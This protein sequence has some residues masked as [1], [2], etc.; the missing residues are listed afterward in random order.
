MPLLWRSWKSKGNE[1]EE[2]KEG[3]MSLLEAEPLRVLSAEAVIVTSLN[4]PLP[5]KN[6]DKYFGEEHDKFN[7]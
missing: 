3:G 4:E 7:C 1:I 6:D 2:E 5:V